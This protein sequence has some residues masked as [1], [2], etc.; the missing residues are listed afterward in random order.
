MM[1]PLHSVQCSCNA[2][3][4]VLQRAGFMPACAIAHPSPK[5]GN[6]V[7]DAVGTALP[8]AAYKDWQ[9]DLLSRQTAVPKHTML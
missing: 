5:R 3:L 1:H 6:V 8:E 7:S 4:R 2:I 9:P